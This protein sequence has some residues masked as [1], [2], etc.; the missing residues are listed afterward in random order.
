MIWV[1]IKRIFR[2]GFL[3]FWR[4]GFVSFASVLMMVF[5]LF[6]IG[7]ALFAGIILQSTLAE[8]R[9]KADMSVYFTVDASQEKMDELVNSV[10]ALPEVSGVTFMSREEAL[11][12]FRERHQND[13][14]TL[15]ALDE[16]GANPLGAV[17]TVK[18]KDI[19][20]YEAI[21]TF[22]RGQEVLSPGEA[23]VI[24][25]INYYDE[26]HRN[27]L[28][29]LSEI[30]DSAK[31]IGL[32]VILIFVVTTVA[33]SFNTLRLAIYSS[34]DEI[35][36]MRLVGANKNYIRAPFIVE[37]ILYGLIAG[38]VTLLLFY[39]LTWW[40]GRATARFFGGISV[41]SYYLGNFP[42]FFLI[43][44]GSGVVLGAVASYLAVRRY[45]KV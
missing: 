42:F 30:T 26:E 9:D 25:K 33:I 27:A 12:Q 22:L 19:S 34:R 18:A 43:I 23:S 31:W 16:L 20:Q 15:Q 21:A 17:F 14:L 6:V 24:D 29:R 32:V 7:L 13:Q 39:P 37:G 36:V 4:N 45:L 35:H 5:T 1:T 2:A 11:A 3:D 41:F 8:F 28:N 44:V 40:L 38:I 10:K